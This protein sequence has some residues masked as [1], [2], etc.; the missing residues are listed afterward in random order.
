M[1]DDHPAVYFEPIE[2]RCSD[3]I[4]G[5]TLSNKKRKLESVIIYRR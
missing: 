1:I 3:R 2:L 4:T 5:T